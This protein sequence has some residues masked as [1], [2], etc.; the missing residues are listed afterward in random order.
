MLAEVGRR[1]VGEPVHAGR[2][3]TCRP[4]LCLPRPRSVRGHLV[5]RAMQVS[6]EGKVA[7]VTG[8]S[9]GIGLAIA[10]SYAEAGAKVML[11]SRK[12]DQLV[13]AAQT[14]DGDT[15][16]FVANVGDVEAR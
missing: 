13:A 4:G 10:S 15:H 9:K 7:L 16:V 1:L 8:A 11:S 12:F 3:S 2:L 5:S 14:I 6:L